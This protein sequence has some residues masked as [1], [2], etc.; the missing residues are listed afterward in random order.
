MTFIFRKA[1]LIGFQYEGTKK[2]PGII[3]DLYK[4]YC[5]LIKH[6]W[7]D[8]EI[9]IL[10]DVTID[11]STE[12]LR[13]SILENTVNSDVLTFI[14]DA[15][16]RKQHF[17]FKS[18]T[19]YNNFSAI[20]TSASN[21]FV[22]YTGHCKDGNIILP[23]YSLLSLDLFKSYLIAENT[24]CIMDCC[25]GGIELPFILNGKIYRCKERLQ[26]SDFIKNKIV[27]ISS[28][29]ENEKSMT[30]RSGSFFTRC[31]FSILED[32][33]LSLFSILQKVQKNLSNIMMLRSNNDFDLKFTQTASISSSYPH[34]FCLAGFLYSYPTFSL[35]LHSSHLVLE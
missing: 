20:F 12:V 14:E 29:I 24:I 7:K 27:C 15:K 26:K 13:N 19:Y 8:D 18:H 25:E 3:T 1:F 10:T 34:I 35:S 4:V 17:T 28:C 9:V 22:Y 33:S 23:N 21:Y 30:S 6:G 31:L 2:L 11:D 5:F 16:E 32:S